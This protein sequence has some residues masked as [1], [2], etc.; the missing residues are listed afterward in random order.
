MIKLSPEA[1]GLLET[2]V[3]DG[4]KFIVIRAEGTVEVNG[5]EISI[6]EDKDK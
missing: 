1:A 2:R 3:I 6:C 5:V 4:Q